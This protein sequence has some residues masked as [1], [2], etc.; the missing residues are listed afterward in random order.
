MNETVGDE[1]HRGDVV[2]VLLVTHMVG[3]VHQR[4]AQTGEGVC[5]MW[6]V[7]TRDGDRTP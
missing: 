2:W 6:E 5:H 3:W 1:Y 4:N 7:G